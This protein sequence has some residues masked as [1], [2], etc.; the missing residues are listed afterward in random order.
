MRHPSGKS[1]EAPVELREK[2]RDLRNSLM[3]TVI[4]ADA[5]IATCTEWLSVVTDY[6][7]P[8]LNHI[9]G[10][11]LDHQ[12]RVVEPPTTTTYLCIPGL[13]ATNGFCHIRVVLYTSE[14][15]SLQAIL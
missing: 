12:V 7:G 14:P 2:T 1:A 3:A 13:L 4:L 6:V 9:S 15:H 10:K 11:F 5:S 8:H